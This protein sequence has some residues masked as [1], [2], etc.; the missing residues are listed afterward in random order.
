[1]S[2]LYSV[3]TIK[4]NKE[5]Y[6]FFLEQNRLSG[7]DH[8][9]IFYEGSLPIDKSQYDYATFI[10]S[11][12]LN[13]GITNLNTR[14][15]LNTKRAVRYLLS[16][17]LSGWITPID[18]DEVLNFN[19]KL[20]TTLKKEFDVIR[21]FPY[22]PISDGTVDRHKHTLYKTS[23]SPEQVSVLKCFNLIE[24][25][26]D[27]F[28]WL[29]GHEQGKYVARLSSQLRYGIHNAHG[30][31]KVYRAKENGILHYESNSFDEFLRKFTNHSENKAGFKDSRRQIVDFFRLYKNHPNFISLAKVIYNNRFIEKNIELKAELGLIFGIKRM[32]NNSSNMYYNASD[33]YETEVVLIPERYADSLRDLAS[34]CE[35]K[36][37]I[38][39][40]FFLLTLANQARPWGK[41]IEK[42]LGKIKKNLSFSDN[43]DFY[44][45]VK[46]EVDEKLV[47]SELSI[48]TGLVR[49]L[50]SL[51]VDLSK[52][53]NI[54]LHQEYADILRCIGKVFSQ[55]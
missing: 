19:K 32:Q 29:R 6:E 42:K 25:P 31:N 5:N 37:L 24:G 43:S 41:L 39:L 45:E 44:R 16:N 10:S 38:H 14:Q 7:V 13:I 34:V 46:R 26:Q 30:A 53:K 27:T 28:E 47:M 55:K 50:Q 1:M 3:S 9:F 51:E 12:E 49:M 2:F 33:I 52:P 18:G 22:E 11:D 36:E 48:D 40:A 21:L 54:G 35:K 4:D 17:N 23:L 20:L 15:L 8:M